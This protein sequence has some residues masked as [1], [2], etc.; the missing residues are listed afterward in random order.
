M[1]ISITVLQRAL[2]E[3]FYDS[4]KVEIEY[5]ENGDLQFSSDELC[6]VLNYR[7]ITDALERH[8]ANKRNP[9]MVHKMLTKHIATNLLLQRKRMAAKVPCHDSGLILKA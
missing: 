4:E 6:Y 3:L 7:M 1:N 9:G 2:D 5:I 8:N